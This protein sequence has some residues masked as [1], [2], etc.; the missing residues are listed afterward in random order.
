[1]LFLRMAEILKSGIEPNCQ[2]VML[3]ISPDE[4]GKISVLE[5]RWLYLG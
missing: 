1:M 5:I 2:K 4:T 3:I